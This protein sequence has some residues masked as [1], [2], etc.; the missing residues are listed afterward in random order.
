MKILKDNPVD[1]SSKKSD[2]KEKTLA[3]KIAIVAV[4]IVVLAV[5]IYFVNRKK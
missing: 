4:P 2:S 5:I 1:V 3:E